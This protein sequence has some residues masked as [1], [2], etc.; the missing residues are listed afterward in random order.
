MKQILFVDDETNVLQGLRRMLRP[1]R[2]KWNMRFAD[3]G[4]AA[5]ELL[6][7][8]TC[9]VII[10]DMRM[11]GMDGAELLGHVRDK[12]PE[13]ARIVLSGQTDKEAAMRSTSAAHQFLAK[14]CDAERLKSAIQR[15]CQ[16]RDF[17][18]NEDLLKV[19]SGLPSLPSM[20]D[21][22]MEL[23]RELASEE[24]SL[25]RVAAIVGRDVALMAKLLQLVNSSFFGFSRH[26]ENI[27]QAVSFLGADVVRGLA[28][29][30][31]VFTRFEGDL[32]QFQ[33]QRLWNHSQATAAI[34]AAIARKESG[35]STVIDQSLQAGMLHDI[36]RLV[37]AAYLPD[38]HNET[39]AIADAEE[40]PVH[41]AE[42]R[43]LGCDHSQIGAYLM[44]LWGLPDAIV[45]AIAYHH[46]PKA[47]V[48]ADFSPTIAVY[49]ANCLVTVLHETEEHVIE[50]AL[51]DLSA[52]ID[53]EEKRAAWARI[54]REALDEQAERD[55]ALSA[56][57]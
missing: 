56:A 30:T 2:N 3:G 11:P 9:D 1:M 51:A 52:I 44:G 37:L 24:M 17:L 14:P 23:T 50:G 32:E 35:D 27:N 7:Q 57:S 28:L 29:S 8:Q 21:I 53:D 6:D 13:A 22:Y 33:L 31:A 12:H 10:S 18:R 38:E 49:A 54:A 4:L 19:V 48:A 26:I 43:I 5:L 15:A 45:E 42:T 36:G 40:I 16:L 46:D 39:V 20:P 55:A 41:L 25:Q 47:C 34:A